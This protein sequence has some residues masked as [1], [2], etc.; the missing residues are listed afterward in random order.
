MQTFMFRFP[1]GLQA[2][3]LYRRR[4]E[5]SWECLSHAA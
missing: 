4:S 1:L 2:R 5:L 3:T